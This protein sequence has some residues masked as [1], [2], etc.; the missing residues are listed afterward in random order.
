MS[1]G[2]G[3]GGR[4]PGGYNFAVNDREFVVMLF[5]RLSFGIDMPFGPPGQMVRAFHPASIDLLVKALGE[6]LEKWTP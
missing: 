5:T 3:D 6:R 2:E 1:P 4:P